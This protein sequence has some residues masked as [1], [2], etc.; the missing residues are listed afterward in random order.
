MLSSL[1]GL[2]W[3]QAGEPVGALLRQHQTS[4]SRNQRKCAKAFRLTIEKERGRW[5]IQGDTTL[6]NLERQVHQRAR[7]DGKGRLRL[8]AC[9]WMDHLHDACI[10]KGWLAGSSRLN[11]PMRSLELLHDRIIDALLLPLE[12]DFD[13]APWI[14]TFHLSSKLSPADDDI[15]L[16]M[17]PEVAAHPASRELTHMLEACLKTVSMQDQL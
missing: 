3:L 4:V 2:L 1:D 16:L 9:R 8:E 5:R 7:L 12:N 10:P 17:R 13:H 14:N 11:E 6:L 15:A